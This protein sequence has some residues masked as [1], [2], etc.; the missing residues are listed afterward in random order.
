MIT[1]D[2]LNRITYEIVM[3]Y[4]W[5]HPQSKVPVTEEHKEAWDEIAIEVRE[6]EARGH[7]VDIP[8]EMPD[9]SDYIPGEI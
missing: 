2:M 8:S 5:G 4:T 3:G 1:T 9:L 6:I 7:V